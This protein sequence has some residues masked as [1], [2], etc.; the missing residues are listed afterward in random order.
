MKKKLTTAG[1]LLLPLL[2]SASLLHAQG[3]KD[4]LGSS[5]LVG[6]SLNQWQSSG[7]DYAAMPVVRKHFNAVVAENVMKLDALQPAEGLYNFRHADEIVRLAED[8]HLALIGHCLVWHS[9]VPSWFFI[10]K[11]GREVSREELIRRVETHIATVVGRYRGKVHGW[12]V[13]NEAIMDDGSMRP[14]PYF[15]IIGEEFIEIAFRA[16]HKAD[17]DAELYYNDYSMALPAKRQ[18]VCQLVRRLQAKGLRIDA[19]GMQSHVG[20]DY[21]D[22]VDYEATIDSLS[23]C[24][25]KVMVSELDLNVLPSPQFMGA[26]IEQNYEY[27]QQWNPYIDGV[28]TAVQEQID[29]RWMELFSIYHR[30]RHQISRINLWGI[31]DQNSWLNDWPIRGRTNYP[32]LF[33]REYREKAVIRRICNLFIENRK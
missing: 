12:D 10:D 15:N 2:L 21:P 26:A 30:H 31:S 29:R 13:V 33:D 24:G 3:L 16:A 6:T 20:L 27:E 7:Q 22:L 32:L 11:Q 4:V 23:A 1:F 18:A 14:S 9:Q 8:N 25:V 17:P 19:V 5:F 28:P